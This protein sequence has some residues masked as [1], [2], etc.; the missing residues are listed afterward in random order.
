M[1]FY[2]R[3]SHCTDRVG[4]GRVG[5]CHVRSES[6]V[7]HQSQPEVRS[8]FILA[9]YIYIYIYI[10]TYSLSM[11][12]LDFGGVHHNMSHHTIYRVAA[13]PPYRSLPSGSTSC[14]VEQ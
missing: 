14:Y 2:I 4:S 12:C 5:S 8:I 6:S 11:S 7:T 9:S 10:Y 13:R 1:M 3:M